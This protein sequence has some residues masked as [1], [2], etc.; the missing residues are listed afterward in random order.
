MDDGTERKYGGEIEFRA[1][2]EAAIAGGYFAS[3]NTSD[4]TNLSANESESINPLGK[5]SSTHVNSIAL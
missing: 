5:Q 1:Q 2:I 3:N 4:S